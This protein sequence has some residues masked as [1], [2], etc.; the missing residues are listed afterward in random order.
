LRAA[1]LLIS[2]APTSRR[3]SPRRRPTILLSW[4]C[5]TSIEAA[6][7]ELPDLN[8]PKFAPIKTRF[9]R[10]YLKHKADLGVPKASDEAVL[11]HVDEIT[12]IL[13]ASSV[14][15]WRVDDQRWKERYRWFAEIVSE[16][17]EDEPGKPLEDAE[18]N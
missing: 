16:L 9:A 1:R 7:P 13:F 18:T 14:R 11:A 4:R 2:R 15:A 8:S 5:L 6:M 3:R 10:A 12:A 17:L